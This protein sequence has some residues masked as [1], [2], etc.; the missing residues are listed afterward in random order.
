MISPNSL[1]EERGGISSR[2]CFFDLQDTAPELLLAAVFKEVGR[3]EHIDVGDVEMGNLQTQ[4]PEEPT[5]Q[6]ASRRLSDESSLPTVVAVVR[7]LPPDPHG[8]HGS[9]NVS[10][11]Q[12]ADDVPRWWPGPR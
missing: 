12:R 7:D 11:E 9:R 4:S 3:N 2:G 10:R 5:P 6:K 1:T 8:P